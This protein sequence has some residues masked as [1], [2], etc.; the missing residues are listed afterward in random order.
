MDLYGPRIMRRCT[1]GGGHV[2]RHDAECVHDETSGISPGPSRCRDG[3]GTGHGTSHNRVWEHVGEAQ[4]MWAGHEGCG[5]PSSVGHAHSMRRSSSG[6][7][8]LLQLLLAPSRS[9]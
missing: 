1:T 7:L 6:D 8:T 2:T 3:V 9:F 5:W 4:D